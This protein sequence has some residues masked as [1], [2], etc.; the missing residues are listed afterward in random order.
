MSGQPNSPLLDLQAI[1]RQKV[2][3]ASFV[4][5]ALAA[6]GVYVGVT[7]PTYEVQRRLV[8]LEDNPALDPPRQGLVDREFLATQAEL[9]RSPV[10]LRRVLDRVPVKVP[11]SYSKGDVAYV[12]ESL[13]VSPVLGTDIL[14][15]GFRSTSAEQAKALTAALVEEYQRHVL[16]IDQGRHGEELALLASQEE[17]LRQQLEEL[18]DAYIEFR[19][20]SPLVGQGREMLAVQTNQ[21]DH[22]G[23]RLSEARNHRIQLENQLQMYALAKAREKTDPELVNISADGA[24]TFASLPI[25]DAAAGD[26]LIPGSA[27]TNVLRDASPAGAED[28]AVVQTQLWQARTREKDL[29]QR[30]GPRHPDLIA[31]REQIRYWEK[32]L[33]ERATVVAAGLK[34]ALEAAKTTE[35]GLKELYDDE[36]K[37]VKNLDDFLVTESAHLAKIARV[38]AVYAATITRQKEHQLTGEALRQ[39]RSSVTI[40]ALDGA[41]V[42]EELVWP[43]PKSFLALC[44]LLGLIASVAVIALR[45]HLKPS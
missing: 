37:Q 31:A 4:V 20:E 36:R 23:Q 2:F 12:L 11:S 18:Q 14:K 33:D 6:G 32:V 44:G 7:P 42:N 17:S 45:T 8:V 35:I 34:H 22:V 41:Q 28:L 26:S 3:V 13:S 10:I 5:L 19:R 24:A 1:W 16:Q 43:Q 38:E 25:Q 40:K 27:A 39:G 9:I 29:S 30:L 15:I 21:L